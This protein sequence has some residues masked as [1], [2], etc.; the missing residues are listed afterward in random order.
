[1]AHPSGGGSPATAI[2]PPMLMSTPDP[3]ASADTSRS[4]IGEQGLGRRSKVKANVPRDARRAA[5]VIEVEVSESRNGT[6]VSQA[7]RSRLNLFEVPVVAE[8]DD[9]RT[10]R[11]VD[12]AVG[13]LGDPVRDV[14]C[15][16]KEWGHLDGPSSVGVEGG[17][18]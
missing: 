11:W 5:C 17:K 10:N 12:R 16:E 18:L 3:N 8:C 7:K 14:Q 6:E 4:P 15:L 13:S 9:G 1:M 2:S